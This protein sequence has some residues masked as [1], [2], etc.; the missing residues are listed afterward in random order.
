[1]EEQQGSKADSCS[2]IDENWQ[3]NTFLQE[4]QK[5][6]LSNFNPLIKKK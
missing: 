4:E 6:A 5:V 3:S 1:M 2:Q